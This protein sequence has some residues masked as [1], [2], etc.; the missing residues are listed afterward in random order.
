MEVI[1]QVQK[2][3]YDY[4]TKKLEAETITPMKILS[5]YED[6]Q[7]TLQNMLVGACQA[8]ADYTRKEDRANDGDTTKR[9]EK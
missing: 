3:A 8:I 1:E 5:A 7:N 4:F 9:K 6:V 2:H